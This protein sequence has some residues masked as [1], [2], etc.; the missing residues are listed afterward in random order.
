MRPRSTI[1]STMLVCLCVAEGAIADADRMYLEEDGIV[2]FEVEDIVPA[3][4]WQLR[5]DI[6]EYDGNGYFEWTGP[7]AFPVSSAGLGTTTYHFRIETAGNYQFRW[8]SYIAIGESN[9]EHNDSWVRLTTGE[10]IPE[11]HPLDGW[12]KV[13]MNNSNSWSWSSNTVD[14]VGEPIRQYFIQGDHTVE[15][16]GRSNGHGIDRIALYRYED[17]PYNTSVI[18]TRE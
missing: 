10:D 18:N 14:H 1:F 11:Q 12:T 15:I 2:L 13:Y 3:E 17:V 7:N 16:S 6:E 8:R 4:G 5:T 9:T